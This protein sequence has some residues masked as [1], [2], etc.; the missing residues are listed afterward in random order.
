[1]LDFDIILG[2]DWLVPYQAILD[3]YAKIVTLVKRSMPLVVWQDTI[4]H[5]QVGFISYVRA[6]RLIST[7]CLAYLAHVIFQLRPILLIWFQW[8]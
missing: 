7:R 2:M 5:T 3:Y 8:L 1:M 4:S 6:Q